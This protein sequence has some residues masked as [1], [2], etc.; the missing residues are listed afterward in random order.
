MGEVFSMGSGSPIAPFDSCMTYTA[1]EPSAARS[2]VAPCTD[3][4]PILRGPS[5]VA[6][7]VGGTHYDIWANYERYAAPV[8]W[9]FLV[10]SMEHGAVVV[11]YRCSTA[12]QCT[13]MRSELEA[14]IDTWPVD[15]ACRGDVRRR[16]ILVP[17]PAL[18]WPIAVL[19]WENM[20]MATC[21]DPVSIRRFADAHY[22]NAP[23]DLCA[24]G[25]NR[26]ATDWCD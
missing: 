5:P 17:E 3:L 25:I 16:V 24:E 12:D 8:P 23:E 6:P 13:A 18:D 11:A 20:Y 26:A 7:P 22:A 19:A 4:G 15:P 14:L 21:I 1:N 2:H 10:H 9:G